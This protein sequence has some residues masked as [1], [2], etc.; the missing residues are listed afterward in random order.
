MTHDHTHGHTHDHAGRVDDALTASKAGM[1][2]VAIS[3]VILAVTVDQL[4]RKGGR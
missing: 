1:R 3:L 4:S 2:A